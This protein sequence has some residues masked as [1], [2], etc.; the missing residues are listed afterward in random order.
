MGRAEAEALSRAFYA[1]LGA[2]GL[3]KRTR[4][5]WDAEIVAAVVELLPPKARVLDAGCGYGRV[6]LP[7][8]RAGFDVCGL[9][10]S[11]QLIDAARRAA[12]AEAVPSRFTV[13][14]MTSL[15][16]AP[17]SFDA[18]ICLWSA[19]HELLDEETQMQSLGEMWRVLRPGGF[20][21]IEGP[22]YTEPSK[23]DVES[24]ARRGHEHRIA[25]TR[26]EGV[27]NP[28]YL[29]DE[30]SFRRICNAAGISRIEVFERDW[31]GRRRLFLR[32]QKPHA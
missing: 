16:Y 31:A 17:A 7:L 14:T 25:W 11:E 6:A 2:D 32:L 20:A 29:H 26:V 18:V 13:G 23:A 10:L 5:E 9:D 8:A 4:P 1:E 28:H 3:A 24:G 27:L 12:A 22:L 15:P 19:F 30:R 21:L